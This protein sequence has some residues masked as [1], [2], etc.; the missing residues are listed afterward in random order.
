[1]DELK[2]QAEALG[3]KVDGRWSEDRLREEIAEKLAEQPAAEE[4]P[5]E[6]VEPESAEPVEPVAEVAADPV[7]PE[8]EIEPE[9]EVDGVHLRNLQANPMLSLGLEGYGVGFIP[10][11]RL[12]AMT[13]KRIQ[14]GIDLGLLRVEE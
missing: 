14:R 1:L 11:H 3:I 6:V 2:K 13:E 8:P 9:V 10:A 7:E 4:A 12:D 5:E